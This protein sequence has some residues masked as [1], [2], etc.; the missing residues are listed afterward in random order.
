MGLSDTPKR[1]G[2]SLAGCRLMVTRHHRRGFPCCVRSPCADMPPPIPRQDRC[3][4]DRSCCL[5]QLAFI[6]GGLPS[7]RGGSAP[8]SPVSGPAQRSLTLRPACSPGRQSDPLHRRLQ[9][10]RYLHCCS[11]CYRV[12]RS[13]SR[14]GVSPAEDQRLFTAHAKAELPAKSPMPASGWPT[15]MPTGMR[16]STSPK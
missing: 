3:R 7:I 8:A 15:R 11:N 9:Q 16:A 10:L 2:L 5:R 13:S 6:D 1:P 12:E 14:A 4:R